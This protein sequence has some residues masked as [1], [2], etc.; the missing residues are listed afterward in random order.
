MRRLDS[1]QAPPRQEVCRGLEVAMVMRREAAALEGVMHRLAAERRSEAKAR[2]AVHWDTR[3]AVVTAQLKAFSPSN[4][5][6]SADV[7]LVAQRAT[8]LA[9]QQSTLSAY[10]KSWSSWKAFCSAKGLS[11]RV[12]KDKLLNYVVWWVLEKRNKATSCRSRL[13]GIRH[14]ASQLA[15]GG[16][17][18]VEMR[19]VQRVREAFRKFDMDAELQALPLTQATILRMKTVLQ[20]QSKRG[21]RCFAMMCVARALALRAGEVVGALSFG[22]LYF[23]GSSLVYNMPPTKASKRGHKVPL[24]LFASGSGTDPVRALRR[25]V[26]CVFGRSLEWMVNNLP[27]QPMFQT[28]SKKGYPTD[29]RMTS[30]AVMQEWRACATRAGISQAGLLSARSG[31]AG[32]VLDAARQILG[33]ADIAAVV[34]HKTVDTTKWYF[35]R[36]AADSLKAW[37]TV[38]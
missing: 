21:A 8:A 2:R 9:R 5:M 16:V 27:T 24:P 38:I 10:Q 22:N 20:L 14:E 33:L 1:G 4:P 35:Q 36:S 15:T 6:Q 18:D 32:L 30:R 13:I 12:S 26:S 23:A 29:R 11:L 34:R 19:Q 37:V 28:L 25:Y 3:A 31:R 17:S 7:G